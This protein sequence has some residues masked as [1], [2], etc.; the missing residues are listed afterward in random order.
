[1]K[2]ASIEKR[3]ENSYRITVSDGYNTKG[4]KLR[5]RKTITL[6]PGLTERQK[7]KEIMKQATL[8]EQEVKTGT[9]LDAGKITFAGFVDRWLKDYAESNLAPATLRRYKDLLYLRI[10]PAIGHIK[11]SSLQPTHLISFY[12]NLKENGLR[13]DGKYIAKPEFQELLSEKSIKVKD[14]SETAEVNERT[15]KGLLS[16][17]STTRKIAD[18]I[19]RSLNNMYNNIKF[20]S[21]FILHG[22]PGKL[23]DE[24]IRY[25]HR[26]I[27]SIL[28]T[29]V[30]WQYIVNSP[31]ERVKPPKVE[32]KEAVCLDEDVTEYMLSLLDNEPIKYRT[33][34]TVAVYAGMRLGEVCG[35][36]WSDID[37]ENNL[38][39]IRQASQYLPDIG[40]FQKDPKNESSIRVIAMPQIAMDMLSKYKAWWNEQK[41][42]C[43]D[44]W[45]KDAYDIENNWVFIQW[46]G[47][48][49]FPDTPSKWFNK[50]IKRHNS[51]ITSDDKIP[52]NDKHK[53]LLPEVSFHKLRHT[54]ASLL[55][56]QGVDIQTV[57]K[58]L[59]HAKA[60]T[61]TNIY[62]HFLKR[63]DMEAA[64]KL[65]NLFN[66]KE[67]IKEVK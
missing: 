49:M 63:P 66:K 23:S 15:I 59:G 33:A 50:F 47:K 57:A 1:M 18:S 65:Q 28:T 10:I 40:V 26:V 42:Q 56:S 37:F 55:I 7:E 48:P 6:D 13:L 8:F 61:T 20:D 38:I 21:I 2:M 46:D 24:S 39:R 27:S 62:S 52:Q 34:V 19:V 16:G 29:A 4:I 22:S 9:Y 54:N 32:K 25:H 53:Y 3:S 64:D 44:L 45:H 17:K 35:L 12:D 60:T 43:G 41:L 30:Q 67:T 5:E 36:E 58:R 31:A 14:L 51:G 11:L